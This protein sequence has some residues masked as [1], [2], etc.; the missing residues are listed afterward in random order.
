MLWATHNATS[1][2]R[3]ADVCA[4]VA[5]A[6]RFGGCKDTPFSSL[7]R[8]LRCEFGWRAAGVPM[9][10]GVGARA[11][12]C[13]AGCRTAAYP[14]QPVELSASPARGGSLPCSTEG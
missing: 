12:R 4:G 8:S 5:V 14:L 1:A 3:F 11:V 10:Y 6:V 7:V 2:Q 13:G 9:P